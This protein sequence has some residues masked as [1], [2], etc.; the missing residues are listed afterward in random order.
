MKRCQNKKCGKLF[1]DLDYRKFVRERGQTAWDK[2][3]KANLCP[4]CETK[5]IIAK[6]ARKDLRRNDAQ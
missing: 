3:S 6:F 1:T 4:E 2:Y 5:R